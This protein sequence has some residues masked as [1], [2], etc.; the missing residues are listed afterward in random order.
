MGEEREQQEEREGQGGG[1]GV[2]VSKCA[3][4]RLHGNVIVKPIICMLTKQV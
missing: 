4:I 3:I 2:T 1:N